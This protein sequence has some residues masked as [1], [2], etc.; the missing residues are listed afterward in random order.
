MEEVE[1]GKIIHLFH[2]WVTNKFPGNDQ[3]TALVVFRSFRKCG[4][5][6]DIV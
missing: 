2:L 4:I 1:G 5:F 3:G 6:V